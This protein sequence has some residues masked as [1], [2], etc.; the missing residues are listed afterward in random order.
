MPIENL[1]NP[2]L[3]TWG[4]ID[5]SITL[6][7]DLNQVL[8]NKSDLNHKH[9][10]ID[11]IIHL[12]E[13]IDVVDDNYHRIAISP[14]LEKHTSYLIEFNILMGD[15]SK[16]CYKLE[17]PYA[18]GGWAVGEMN[19]FQSNPQ[20]QWGEVI[21][22]NMNSLEMEFDDYSIN[23]SC[24]IHR[25]DK[26]RMMLHTGEYG[27]SI[28]IYVKKMETTYPDYEIKKNSY[29]NYRILSE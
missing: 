15:C 5:G 9:T 17:F 14:E 10:G 6:Q 19:D 27:G 28:N 2:I 23:N 24:D 18:C 13:D 22:G 7:S 20:M 4:D 11:K 26:V 3:P 29:L 25:I 12:T 8:E 21:S 16:V 1:V